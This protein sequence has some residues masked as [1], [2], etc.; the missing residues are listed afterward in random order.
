MPK[1][2]EPLIF[3]GEDN[4]MRESFRSDL[5]A[6]SKDRPLW[7]RHALWMLATKPEMTVADIEALERC[8]LKEVDLLEALDG[9]APETLFEASHLRTA[10]DAAVRLLKVS[11]VQ[12]VNRLDSAGL[13]FAPTGLTIV[14]GE[15]GSGKT[16]FIR[17]LRKA[18]RTRVEKAIELEI[19]ANIYGPTKGSASADFTIVENGN[20]RTIQW[21][22]DG[23]DAD[24]RLG[25]FSVFDTRSAQLY[26]DEGNRL[27]FLPA[28]LDIP[29]RL[30]DVILTVEGRIEPQLRE[31]ENLL[32]T[33]GWPF[34]FPERNTPARAFYNRLSGLTTDQAIDTACTFLDGDK[35]RLAALSDALSAQPSRIADLRG[36]ANAARTLSGRLKTL[37]AALDENHARALQ[38]AWQKKREAQSTQDATRDLISGKDPLPGVGSEIWK[39]LWLAAQRYA[40]EADWEHS[41]PADGPMSASGEV[42]CP[43][44]Q[45]NLVSAQERFEA[46]R[47]IYV[48]QN[49]GNAAP[50]RNRL[51]R[52]C[53][54]AGPGQ[55][56]SERS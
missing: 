18:C 11:N 37:E 38:A 21:A 33:Q 23:S 31:I 28:D 27:R 8:L 3:G 15:N 53:W 43:L 49:G 29:F 40:T 13:E 19:L 39:E 2:I 32:R 16:G 5:E 48:R 46:L 30:N 56:R 17:V 24:Q 41:F 12:N 34:D 54:R 22:D 47:S 50:R 10:P 44:C 45:Q 36:K 26:V 55:L 14:Y 35:E 7:Q 42:V 6:W 51:K 20:E 25:A 9:E 1:A 4:E 52:A